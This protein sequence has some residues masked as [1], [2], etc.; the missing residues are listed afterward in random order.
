MPTLGNAAW[1]VV[2]PTG[3]EGLATKPGTPSGSRLP[4]RGVE[5][6]TTSST[7]YNLCRDITLLHPNVHE[8]NK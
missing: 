2:V 4:C 1:R 8:R 5:G 7:L 3:P 6:R